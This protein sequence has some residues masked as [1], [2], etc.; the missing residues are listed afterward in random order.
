MTFVID[1]DLERQIEEAVGELYRV[2]F[3]MRKS[4]LYEQE[5]TAMCSLKRMLEIDIEY[6]GENCGFSNDT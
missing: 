5:Y 2:F 4:K 6:L 3:L 1:E